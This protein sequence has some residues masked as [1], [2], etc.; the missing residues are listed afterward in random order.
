MIQ[1]E[2]A[3]QLLDEAFEQFFRSVAP[4]E[5]VEAGLKKYARLRVSRA[6]KQVPCGGNLY[7][8]ARQILAEKGTVLED[9]PERRLLLAT[10]GGV[11]QQNPAILEMLFTEESLTLTAWA[12][13][14][15]IP[16]RTAQ[17]AVRSALSALG[18]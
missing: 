15:L 8:Q 4:E 14:G 2:R 13:E 3:G 18:L 9:E 7:S 11:K 16:Q 6:D 10:G 1:E 12:K 5:V 17:G